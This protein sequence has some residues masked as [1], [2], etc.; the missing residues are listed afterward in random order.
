MPTTLYFV[1]PCYKD[2]KVLPVTGPVF[3][4]KL[5]EL[6]KKNAVSPDSR[7]LLVNDGSPDDT[8][9]AIK[10][11]HETDPRIAGVNLA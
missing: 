7:V 8:W 2:E 4:Q 11:L 3:L 9:G 1:V 10:A 5:T 6:I